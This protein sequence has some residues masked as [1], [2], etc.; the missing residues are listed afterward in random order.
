MALLLIIWGIPT[1]IAALL[2]LPVILLGR[3]RV[4][5]RLWELLAL[6]LPFCVWISSGLVLSHWK[7]KGWGNM[8]EPCFFSI[9]IPVAAIVRVVVGRK[10]NETVFSIILIGFLCLVAVIVALVTP[11]LGGSL[12]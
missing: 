9:G 1:G 5:W 11:D 2:S 6:V 4:S 12:G 3:H 10:F 8:I 7:T